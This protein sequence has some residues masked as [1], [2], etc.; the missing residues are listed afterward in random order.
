MEAAVACGLG[1]L[2]GRGKE[3]DL[4]TRVSKQL[5][6][7]RNPDRVEGAKHACRPVVH[8]PCQFCIV[9]SYGGELSPPAPLRT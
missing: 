7:Q 5:K 2:S 6:Q 8:V 4:G 9:A 3:V 1:G